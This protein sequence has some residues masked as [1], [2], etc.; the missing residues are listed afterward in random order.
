MPEPDRDAVREHVI[1][2]VERNRQAVA[3]LNDAIFWFAEPGLQEH[4]TSALMTSLLEEAGF[5]VER[6]ISGFPTAFVATAGSGRPVVA[7]HTEYDANPDNSQMPGVAEKREIVPGAPGHCEGHNANAAAMVAAAI[8]VKSAIDTMGLPGTLRVFG[9]PAEELLLARPYFVRDGWF[10]DVDAAFHD[11]IWGEL[12]TEYGQIQI[13]SVSAEFTFHGE[14]AHA[15]LAPWKGRDALD[16]VVLMDMGLAQYREHMQP[17]MRAHRAITDGGVQPNVIPARASVWW[18]FRDPSADGAR[19]LFEQARRIAEGAAL[20]TSTELEVTV[21]SAVWPVRG[22]R[23]L[24]EC[25]QRNIERVGMPRWSEQEQALARALQRA[26]GVAQTGLRPQITPLTG[27][28]KTIMASNDCGDVSWKVPMA[29]LWF[30]GNVPGITYHHWSAGAALA[31]SIAH[32]G[33]VAGAKALAASVAECLADPSVVEEARSTF[34]EEIAGTPYEPL[35]PPEQAPP[36]GANEA[37]MQR[38]RPLLE[39]HYTG[40]RPVFDCT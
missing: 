10:D 14:S 15:G 9:A 39:K 23:T 21:K 12:S 4:E 17:T 31:T 11:H 32:K 1:A 35:L 19:R 29:R 37:L 2:H 24:A 5:A 7:M 20:M 36:S 8:A 27:P 3:D 33:A 13:A 34:A 22:N 26:A 28:S 6:G 30:P 38:Y 16:A 40:K 18:Y 25:V